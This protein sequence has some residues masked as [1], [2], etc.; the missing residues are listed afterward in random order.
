MG[1]R[2]LLIFNRTSEP[3]I[4]LNANVFTG[5]ADNAFTAHQ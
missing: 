3:E 1:E 4:P 2:Y 5:P